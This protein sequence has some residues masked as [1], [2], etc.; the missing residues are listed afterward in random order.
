M[1]LVTVEEARF[2]NSAAALSSGTGS[3]SALSQQPRK[4]FPVA[5]ATRSFS[6]QN[7]TGLQAKEHFVCS[8]QGVEGREVGKAGKGPY[9]RK[10]SKTGKT[11]LPCLPINLVS[12]QWMLRIT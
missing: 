5:Q 9:R 7:S 12:S 2:A 1:T 6:G 10:K 4:G 3:T 11:S 8:I